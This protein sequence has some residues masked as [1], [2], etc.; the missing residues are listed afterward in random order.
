M[1]AVSHIKDFLVGCTPIINNAPNLA[2]VVPFPGNIFI[3]KRNW[4]HLPGV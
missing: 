1:S 3:I 4:V 2:F